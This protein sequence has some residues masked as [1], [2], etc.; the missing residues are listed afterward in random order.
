VDP[1]DL[2]RTYDSIIRI[3]GQSGKGGIAY[4]LETVHGVAL[5]LRLQVELSGVVQRHADA[6]GGEITPDELWAI[7]SREYLEH[8]EP[9]AY[10]GHKLVNGGQG[11]EVEVEVGGKRLSLFG[12]GNGPIDALV[13]ALGLP[14][15]LQSY[16]ERSTGVGADSKAAAFVEVA[17]EGGAGPRFGVGVD[18]NIVTAS[19][20]AVFSAVNRGFV[21]LDTAARRRLLAHLEAGAPARAQ[22]REGLA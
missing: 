16:E 22:P 6:H 9:I 7:F 17:L 4:I 1:K 10:L 21:G 3:N 5:P 13:H 19:V 14:V 18:T 11:L 2:G 8:R 20:L 15:R 12:R